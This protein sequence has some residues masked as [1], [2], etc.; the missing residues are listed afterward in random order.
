M[1]LVV[2]ASV[3]VGPATVQARH[4]DQVSQ[5]DFYPMGREAPAI[6][7]FRG[8]PRSRSSLPERSERAGPASQRTV[9]LFGEG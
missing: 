5:G 7:P 9:G 8:L 6:L 1:L 4:V 2:L 3:A